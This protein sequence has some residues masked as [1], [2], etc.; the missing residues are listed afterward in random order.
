MQ[1]T[2]STKRVGW[3]AERRSTVRRHEFR[4]L[5]LGLVISLIGLISAQAGWAA[6]KY[7]S[8]PIE[9]VCSFQPG[10]A[11][12]VT[13]RLFAKF[14]EKNLGVSMIPTNKPGAGG[15]I[16]VTYLVNSAPDGYKIA[17]V[18]DHMVSAIILGQATYTLEDLRV[19]AQISLVANTISVSADAPWKTFQELVD[20]A[21]KN[22]GLKYGHQGIGSSAHIRMENLN[23]LANLKMIGVPFKGDGETVPALLGKH[24]PV[25][26]VGAAAAKSQ[27]DAGKLRIL[28]SF[29]PPQEIGLDTS[30]PYFSK[31]YGKDTP[32]IDIPTYII[33]PKAT[34]EGVVQVLKSAVEKMANDPEFIKENQK[35]FFRVHYVDGDVVMKTLLPDKIV[36]LKALY[37]EVGMVK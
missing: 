1:E 13:N 30:I 9:I 27:A 7:P 22:P 29:E 24:V 8:R 32:D 6:D 28:F 18:S 25:A 21:T 2:E 19:V 15:V 23:K 3:S 26:V 5:L 12:D 20:Y 37:K 31:F 10:G 17:N 33:V 16:G 14:L 11:A 35:L 34:P 4:G 36:R